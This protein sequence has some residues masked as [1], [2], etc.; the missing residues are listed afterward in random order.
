[1]VG[2]FK[3]FLD[4]ANNT[5]FWIRCDLCSRTWPHLERISI[6]M[7]SVHTSTAQQHAHVHSSVLRINHVLSIFLFIKRQRKGD[8]MTV[9]EQ[10]C[11]LKEET[12]DSLSSRQMIPDL[13]CTCLKYILQ[14]SQSSIYHDW[15]TLHGCVA[16]MCDKE[17]FACHLKC[18]PV[19]FLGHTWQWKEA[20]KMQLYVVHIQPLLTANNITHDSTLHFK[21]NFNKIRQI[22]VLDAFWWVFWP[23]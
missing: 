4:L 15:G 3:F 13:G 21:N 12:L 2:I 17:S 11:L 22:K 14:S 6:P 23:L 7:Q 1:M 16:C 8:K 9:I 20:N 5:L 18:A 10:E 19:D